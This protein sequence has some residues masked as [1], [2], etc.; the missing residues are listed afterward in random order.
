[1]N[2][3]K[4]R[5]IKPLGDSPLSR[6]RL[7]QMG[8]ASTVSLGLS[9]ELP[10]QSGAEDVIGFP[11][12][13][14]QVMGDALLLAIDSVSLPL[15]KNLVLYLSKPAVHPYP[16]LTPSRDKPDPDFLG[17]QFYGTVRDRDTFRMW[18]TAV[19]LGAN[20]DWPSEAKAQLE[21]YRHTVFRG[22][23]CY[24]ESGDG[25]TW[26]KP[27]LRRFPFKGSRDHNAL[28]IPDADSIGATVI[29]DDEDPDPRRRYKLA[30]VYYE[31]PRAGYRGPRRLA[32]LR[33]AVSTNGLDWEVGPRDLLDDIVEQGSF[34]KHNRVYIFNAQKA[35]GAYRG[36]GGHL[37]GMADWGRDDLVF[38]V[39]AQEDHPAFWQ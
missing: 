22:P 1:M 25:I 9:R 17:T 13:G 14:I 37:D 19:S 4:G 11:A 26:N 38:S 2:A 29:K 18:Y 5:R 12:A 23:F 15:R 36:D 3:N 39:A 28:A 8:S 35:G 7:I 33:T 32:S 6:R 10:R 27:N 24:A 34:Y 21:S 30:Y 16:V 31:Y 20:P